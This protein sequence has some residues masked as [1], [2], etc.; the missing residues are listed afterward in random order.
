MDCPSTNNGHV[1]TS[2]STVIDPGE[3]KSFNNSGI[4]TVMAVA[5][6]SVKETLVYAGAVMKWFVGTLEWGKHGF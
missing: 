5:G 1:I 4:I 6:I 2:G 3:R